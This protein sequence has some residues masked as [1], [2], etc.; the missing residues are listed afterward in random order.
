MEDWLEEGVEYITCVFGEEKEEGT[1]EKDGKKKGI[2]V[3]QKGTQ[4]KMARVHPNL[5]R[6]PPALRIRQD[7]Q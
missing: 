4:A 2:P 5:L 7:F 1:A 6:P 3:V